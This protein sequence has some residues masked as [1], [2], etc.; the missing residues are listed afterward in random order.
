MTERDTLLE[1]IGNLVERGTEGT[2][3]DFKLQ[4]HQNK[5]ELI[6][7]VL[8]LANAD[9]EGDRFLIFGVEDSTLAVHSVDNTANRRRQADIAGLFRD[10]AS[11]F[12]QS[13]IPDFHLREVN[14]NGGLLDVLVIED[15]PQKPYYLVEDYKHGSR[16]VRAYHI[17][18]RMGDT[19][20]PLNAAAPPH[21]VERMWRGRF[22]LDMSPLERVK[23]YVDDP[24]EWLPVSER[25]FSGD[26]VYY[27]T[28]FP[29]FTLRYEGLDSPWSTGNE[30]WTRGEVAADGTLTCHVNLHYHQT[31]LHRTRYVSFDDRRK[32]M[33]APHREP[34]G[35]GRFYFYKADSVDYA[36]KRFLTKLFGR[37]DSKSLR[38]GGE[39]EVS[40][41]ARL[42]WP[43]G[44]A[45]PVV[46]NRELGEF[47]GPKASRMIVEPMI[48]QAEQYRLFL[49]NQIDFERWRRT[50]LKGP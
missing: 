3:W 50:T 44:M 16:T 34:R 25:A 18:T 5:A 23:R 42:L 37:D 15:K 6:H 13:R 33:I 31:L 45:I 29:E 46:D 24:G 8:C 4:H 9:H 21:E 11:K 1:T 20:T 2:Y 41:Q 10:N 19:N 40:N 36:V 17:Y 47:L 48:D 12:F 26:E 7:D 14:Y 49:R 43:D 27:Y 32:S 38:V 28:P 39:S 30:E 35:A 22:G